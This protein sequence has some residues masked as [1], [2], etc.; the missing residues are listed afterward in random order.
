MQN[1]L[2]FSLEEGDPSDP[3][4]LMGESVDAVL[5]VPFLNLTRTVRVEDSKS[6]QLLHEFDLSQAILTFCNS[7][8]YDDEQCALSDL[9]ND[10]ILD[11]R[12][13]CPVSTNSDQSDLDRDYKGDACDNCPKVSN[14]NQEDTFPPQGNGIGD[15]CDCESDFSCD[16][17]VDADDVTAFLADFW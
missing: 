13:N 11:R 16:G 2:E 6:G 12:D 1:P 14:R 7:V 4:I 5:V 3:T 10:G 15:A 8:G 17:D 9:D